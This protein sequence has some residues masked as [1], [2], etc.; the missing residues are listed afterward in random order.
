MEEGDFKQAEYGDEANYG[1]LNKEEA[2]SGTGGYV[3]KREYGDLPEVTSTSMKGGA[4]VEEIEMVELLQWASSWQSACK[5]MVSSGG[6]VYD[7][8]RELL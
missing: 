7:M 5:P 8:V 1:D 4:A 6:L 3:E 2:S